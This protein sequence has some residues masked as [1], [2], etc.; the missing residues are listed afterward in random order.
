MLQ[1]RRVSR[2][3]LGSG[4]EVKSGRGQYRHVQGLADVAS[5]FGAVCMLVQEA[6]AGCEIQQDGASKHGK[7]PARI[8]PSEHNHT[9]CMTFPISL[10]P[11]DAGG[12]SWC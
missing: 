1:E 7:H 2:D 11:L 6:A 8:S 10:T 3:Q 9:R 4:D 12:G 5:G